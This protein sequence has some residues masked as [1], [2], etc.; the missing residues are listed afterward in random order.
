MPPGIGET[1]SWF[2]TRALVPRVPE[3]LLTTSVAVALALGAGLG[4][5]GP[6]RA[7]PAAAQRA[8]PGTTRP[9]AAPPATPGPA[10]PGAPAAG[11]VATVPGMP[12][13]VDPSNLYSET[14]AG[15]MSP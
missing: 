9:P 14:R 11:G 5:T 6:L 4:A 2:M 8:Q 12:P 1:R 7:T 15:M 3:K 13:V 10:A